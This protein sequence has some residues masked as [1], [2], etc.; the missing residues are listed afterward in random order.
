MRLKSIEI[1]GFKSFA[2]ESLL[3]FSSPITGVVGPNGSG[4]SNVVESVR[5]ALGEQSMKSMRGKTGSD[6]IFKGSKFLPK[7]SRAS[8]TVTFDNKENKLKIGDSP[9]GF[10]EASITREVFADG[11]SRYL[12][13]GSETRL[14]DIFG[15][16]ASANIGS[17]GHHIISQGE[18]DRVLNASPRDRREMVEDALGL[19]I[20]QMRLKE[21][22]RKLEKTNENL[23]EVKLLRREIAPHLG[24]LKKQVE[25]IAKAEEMRSELKD[26]YLEYFHLESKRIYGSKN[27]YNA[28]L[29]AKQ[30][31]LDGVESRLRGV[32]K[33]E[34][35][36]DRGNEILAQIQK[37]ENEIASVREGKAEL[38]RQLGRLEGMIELEEKRNDMP[39]V[40][41]QDKTI[42]FKSSELLEIIKN[43]EDYADQAIAE[44]TVDLF[45]SSMQNIKN[46]LVKLKPASNSQPKQEVISNADQIQELKEGRESILNEVNKI[47]ETEDSLR[48]KISVQHSELDRERS[49][50]SESSRQKFDLAIKKQELSSQISIINMRM[51]TLEDDSARMTEELR[52]AKALTS[53]D[54]E[55]YATLEI[56]ASSEPLDQESRKKKIDRLKIK[57]EDAGLAG[58]GDVM[59]EHQEVSDR[60]AFLEKEITDLEQGSSSLKEL[61][62]ELKEKL[63]LEFKSGI[64]KINKQFQNFFELMFGGGTAFLSLITEQKRKY[65][66][67]ADGEETEEVL[68]E[69]EEDKFERGIEINVSLPKKKA[70]ELHPLSGEERSL[71]SIAL[72]FAISQVNPP[73]FLVLDETDAAL[74]E[75]NSRKY[76]DML[77]NL[78]KY[79]QLVVVT[80]NRE[81]MSRAGS[82][83]GVTVG[84]DGA[85]KLLS[86]KFDEAVA[87]AK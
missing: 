84:S 58:G 80:H 82:L 24:F 29:K 49:A 76:G 7:L 63:D 65:K 37:K 79:S 83:F 47:S 38:L 51:H 57:L 33:T 45:Q 3:D 46:I 9:L 31:E 59:K 64:E 12:I 22:E 77:E 25:K 44:G 73:P 75:A 41:E 2:K 4:K 26:L 71:T 69:R 66:K 27:S 72:L 14:K 74:D 1:H 15:I 10:Q 5:F 39:K 86:V 50:R 60:D 13:N 35:V 16:L 28:E 85:S 8:V 70:K 53:H 68:E 56:S 36:S 43:I 20:Y 78:A 67:S 23:K 19:K 61:M 17:S 87:I 32:E 34:Q 30:A 21:S 18:A 40:P 42:Y 62:M 48:Q 52:E 6:L 11:T 54:V 55:N 81:T